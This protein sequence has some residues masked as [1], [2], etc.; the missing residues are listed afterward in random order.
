LGV[1]P[2][3]LFHVENRVCLSRGVQVAGVTW[4]AMMRIMAGVGDLMQRTRDGQ[5]QVGY[6]VV[7]RSGG[8][9]TPCAIYIMH[10]KTRSTGFLVEPQN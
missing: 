9:V 1:L 6:S 10:K 5:A 8:R 2:L 4:R 7:R 3:S